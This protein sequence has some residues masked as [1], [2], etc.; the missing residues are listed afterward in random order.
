MNP[1]VVALVFII[2]WLVVGFGAFVI[3]AALTD[4]RYAPAR[5]MLSRLGAIVGGLVLTATGLY[6]LVAVT[7]R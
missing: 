6:G 7:L 2:G 4:R 5:P 1:I 3:C